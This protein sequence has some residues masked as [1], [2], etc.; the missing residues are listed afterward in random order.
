MPVSQTEVAFSPYGNSLNLVL[1]GINTAKVSIMVAAYSF[2]S[3][4]ITEA[5]RDAHKRGVD[6][7]C[8]RRSEG[9]QRRKYTAVAFLANQGVPVRFNGRY[10]IFHNKF[11]VI[12]GRNVET[13]SFNYSVAAVNKNAENVLVLRDVPELAA[14]YTE[15]WE[16]M[17]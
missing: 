8:R 7:V 1:S 14:R 12:D 11:M 3:K 4:P 16:A 10:A 6:V 9:Q 5:L 2:T 17:G 13:G 15:E